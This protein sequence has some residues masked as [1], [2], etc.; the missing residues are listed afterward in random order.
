[1]SKHLRRMRADR[2]VGDSAVFDKFE[3][4]V[5]RIVFTDACN[6]EAVEDSVGSPASGCRTASC[7]SPLRSTATGIMTTRRG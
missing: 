2:I 1:M 4:D 5:A 3:R 7:S 6:T